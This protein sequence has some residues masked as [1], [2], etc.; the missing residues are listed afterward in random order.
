[1]K[2]VCQLYVVRGPLFMPRGSLIE[3]LI[4]MCPPITRANIVCAEPMPG[5]MDLLKEFTATL[6]PKVLGQ[7]VEVVFQ[8]MKLAGEAGSLL[9]IEEDMDR[10]EQ[11]VSELHDFRD[12]LRRTADSH[13][14]PDLNDGVV[15]NIAP[16]RELV[17]WKEAKKSWEELVEAKYEGSSI[18]KQLREKGLVK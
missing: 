12:K 6:Q 11:F 15:L 3:K 5:E 18:S 7:L 4:R 16:L 2:G 9:E 17:P 8:K 14:N 1:M 13:L 10:Q